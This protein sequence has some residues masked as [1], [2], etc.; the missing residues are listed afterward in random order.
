M[1]FNVSWVSNKSLEGR[2]TKISKDFENDIGRKRLNDHSGKPRTVFVDNIHFA[3]NKM[4]MLVK[5]SFS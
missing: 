1:I 3:G 5:C 2:L 4:R